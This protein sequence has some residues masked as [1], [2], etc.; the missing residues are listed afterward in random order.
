[1]IYSTTSVSVAQWQP[2]GWGETMSGA[3]TLCPPQSHWRTTQSPAR[4]M[5]RGSPGKF[6][7]QRNST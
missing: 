2:W 7:A 6:P 4:A 3:L 5:H 1:M